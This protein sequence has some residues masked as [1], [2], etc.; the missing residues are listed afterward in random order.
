MAYSFNTGQD[1]TIDLVDSKGISYSFDTIA[2]DLL[3]FEADWDMDVIRRRPM[4]GSGIA[5]RRL[6]FKGCKGTIEIGRV[7]S[8]FEQLMIAAQDNYRAGLDPVTYTIHQTVLDRDNTGSQSVFRFVNCTVWISKGA[9]YTMGED[10]KL[11]L[12]FE[13]D[14]VVQDQ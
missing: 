3:H 6:D 13:G 1:C 8:D 5:K 10:T 14:D 2:G 4:T 7:N 9:S 12:E 11:S